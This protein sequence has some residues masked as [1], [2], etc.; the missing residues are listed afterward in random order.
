WATG[1][2]GQHRTVTVA[3]AAFLT[4]WFLAAIALAARGVIPRELAAVPQPIAAGLAVA[5]VVGVAFTGN[6]YDVATDLVNGRAR[7]FSRARAAGREPLGQCRAAPAV[8]C[9]IPS[10]AD[11]PHALFVPDETIDADWMVQAYGRYFGVAHITIAGARE[12][13]R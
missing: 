1:I 3:Y 9:V 8:P 6:G 5:L 7:A 4:L 11:P 12:P 2:L 10:M 13:R